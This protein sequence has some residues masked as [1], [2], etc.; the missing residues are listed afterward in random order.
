MC[1]CPFQAASF[2]LADV[3]YFG[4]DDFTSLKL[5]IAPLD[6]STTDEVCEDEEEPVDK[7]RVA[8]STDDGSGGSRGEANAAAQIAEL[9]PERVI[10]P[11]GLGQL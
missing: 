4:F 3:D 9:S 2:G 5:E 6:F 10:R 11:L 1:C 8:V 7:L